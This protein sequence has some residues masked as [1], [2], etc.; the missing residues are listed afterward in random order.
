MR[1]YPLQTVH[2][3]QS[4]PL[5]STL[6]IA[7]RIILLKVREIMLQIIFTVDLHAGKL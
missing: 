5:A 7:T 2:D 4:T 6:S 3:L 1:F